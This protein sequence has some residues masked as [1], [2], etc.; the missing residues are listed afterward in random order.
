MKKRNAFTILIYILILVVAFS[1][2]MGIFG[3]GSGDISYSEMVELFEEG[4]VSA[5]TAY[6]DQLV[7]ELSESVN[8]KYQMTVIIADQESFR[9]EMA[10]IIQTQREA[11]NLEHYD[12]VPEDKL[13]PFDFVLP[14]ILAGMVILLLP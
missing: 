5:F 1:W 6:E 4:K 9:R 7:L 12:F 3:T 11:G 10:D 14:I 2:L 8:G 13:G